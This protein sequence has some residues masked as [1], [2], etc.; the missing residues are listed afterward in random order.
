MAE[1]KP[2]KFR[3]RLDTVLRVR[4]IKERQEQEDFA[5]KKREF[6]DE[7]QKEEKISA[8]QSKRTGELKKMIRKGPISDFA[9]VLHRRAHLG[10]VK[11]DLEKQ[12]QKVVE[13]SQKLEEQRGKLIEAM[14]DK[15]IIDRHKERQLDSWKKMMQDL[16]TKFLDEIG[17]LRHV[18]D[19][20]K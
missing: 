7:K 18:R 14:K 3:Y 16:E 15:K 9:K 17:T 11:E 20:M 4:E 2:G 19:K 13:S 10:V 8:H 12:V 1:Q 5:K 6:L